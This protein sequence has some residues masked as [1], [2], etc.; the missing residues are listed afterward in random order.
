[1]TADLTRS[2]PPGW[3]VQGLSTP[4]F[5]GANWFRA[6][7]GLSASLTV[8]SPQ[9]RY[10]TL[11]FQ[12]HSAGSGYS[13]QITQDGLER[14]SDGVGRGDFHDAYVN[15]ALPAGVSHL[16]LEADCP[17]DACLPLHLYGLSVQTVAARDAGPLQVAGAA[18]LALLLGATLA[19]WLR[20]IGPARR[21]PLPPG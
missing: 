11:R 12:S 6:M 15:L 2:L 20:L 3:S 21:G 5:D 9:P 8:Q 17:Q 16:R 7:P 1:M 18:L 19:R 10:V 14:L 13:F 4:Q